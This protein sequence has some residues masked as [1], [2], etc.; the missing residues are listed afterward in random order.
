MQGQSSLVSSAGKFSRSI[1]LVCLFI[2]CLGN[3][4]ILTQVARVAMAT[5]IGRAGSH[6]G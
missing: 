2:N 1:D 6:V 4:K 3:K 5:S